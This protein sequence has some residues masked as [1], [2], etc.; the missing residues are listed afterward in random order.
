MNVGTRSSRPLNEGVLHELA[1]TGPDGKPFR[2]GILCSRPLDETEVERWLYFLA[3]GLVIRRNPP[4][5][6]TF[7]G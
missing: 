4:P 6:P 3:G 1:I 2:V 5:M 7:L